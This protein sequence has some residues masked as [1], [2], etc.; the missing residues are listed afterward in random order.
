MANRHQL[1]P[2][3][4]ERL[5]D[6]VLAYCLR[7]LGEEQAARDVTQDTLMT[8]WNKRAEFEHRSSLSTWVTGIARFKC[9]AQTRRR[10]E[11]LVED[12]ILDGAD[13]APSV[14]AYRGLRTRERSALLQQAMSEL[15]KVEQDAL[16]MR[17]HLGMAV[18]QITEALRLDSATGAR[19]L[20]QKSRRH[21][22]RRLRERLRDH[23]LGT[24]FLRLT[25]EGG[26]V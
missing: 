19:G 21:L 24:S 14:S 17:Y 12:E 4:L 23:G 3:D 9:M 8:A 7:Y 26:G 18:A 25:T 6:R 5:Q 22:Q 10:A 2:H 16:Y 11:L 15:P 20:L 1:S 13:D